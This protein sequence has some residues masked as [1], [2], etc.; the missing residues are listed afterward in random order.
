MTK[1]LSKEQKRENAVVDILNK[2][3]EIA[4]HNVTFEDIKG[5]QDAWYT[6]WTMTC[7]QADEWKDW[8]ISYLR[9]NLKLNKHLAEREMQWINLQWGLKYSDWENYNKQS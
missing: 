5:R 6:E 1:R 3:F 4:G 7:A 8:G 9:E 2:M